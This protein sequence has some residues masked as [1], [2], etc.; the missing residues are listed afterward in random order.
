MWKPHFSD[1]SDH[2]VLQRLLKSGFHMVATNA[3]RFFQ[4][5]QRSYGNQPLL[6]LRFVGQICLPYSIATRIHP[7]HSRFVKCNR[8]L[9]SRGDISKKAATS[10]KIHR[11]GCRNN[12]IPRVFHLRTRLVAIHVRFTLLHRLSLQP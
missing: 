3:E 7:I 12:L 1:R 2:S 5:S 11:I 8:F 10:I 9:L 4:R 6:T